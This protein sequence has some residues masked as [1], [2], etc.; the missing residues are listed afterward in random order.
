MRKCFVCFCA[1]LFCFSC[2][3]FSG[4]D[5]SLSKVDT[6]ALRFRR[7]CEVF[8]SKKITPEGVLSTL[9]ESCIQVGEEIAARKQ[10]KKK[11]RKKIIWGV[12]GTVLNI[13]S[14]ALS[15]KKNK[16]FSVNDSGL[17]VDLCES[18]FSLQKYNFGPIASEYNLLGR[19]Y[20]LDTKEKRELE[21]SR[22]LVE[23]TQ[24]FLTEIFTILFTYL[25][26]EMA[27]AYEYFKEKV[28]EKFSDYSCIQTKHI[29]SHEYLTALSKEAYHVF[30]K[31]DKD[32]F[33]EDFSDYLMF[34]KIVS[35]FKELSNIEITVDVA[36]EFTSN[37]IEFLEKLKDL[38]YSEETLYMFKELSSIVPAIYDLDID[39]KNKLIKDL[40]SSEDRSQRFI[41]DLLLFMYVFLQERLSSIVF[42]LFDQSAFKGC[43]TEN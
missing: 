31:I 30:E 15:S 39:G 18:L 42:N 14:H 4:E 41:S 29:V 43:S 7:N 5:F 9:A 20:A 27:R 24:E 16:S 6:V 2:T 37:L 21:I 17:I 36:Y 1:F 28:F 13:A 12:V 23:K 40:F 33:V 32:D 25:S 22:L 34:T 35:G 8:R 10:E 11:K 38:F 19:V 26:G 3:A